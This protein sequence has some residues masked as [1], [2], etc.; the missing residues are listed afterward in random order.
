MNKI[1]LKNGR[2]NQKLKTRNQILDAAK[3]LM[4]KNQKTSLE[5]IAEKAEVS[6]ATIYRYFPNIELLYT[7]ASLHIHCSSPTEL[8]EEVKEMSLSKALL[9]VQAYYNQL[10]QD[11]ELIFRRYLIAVLSESVISKKKTR[12]G[13]RIIT[14][15]MVL[16]SYKDK[17]PNSDLEKLKN[18]AC[19]LMGADPLIVAKDV[20]NLS[21]EETNK[22]LSWG[23]E[24]MLK[25]I[26]SE[27]KTK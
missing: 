24:M 17:I 26:F 12:A 21:N 4:S 20:C 11:H 2:I 18:I 9:T 3:L 1:S 5:D 6:R 10:A 19:I 23:L 22:T 8:A 7:E 14:L 13:R 15:E 27:T 25:G 16:E